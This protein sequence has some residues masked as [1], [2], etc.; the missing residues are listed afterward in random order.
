MAADEISEY[1]ENKTELEEIKSFL[2]SKVGAPFCTNVLRIALNMKEESIASIIV[3]YYSINLDEK[4]IIRA[5][6]TNQV[7]FLYFVYAFNKNYERIL[8]L[9]ADN[10]SEATSDFSDDES[11]YEQKVVQ[12]YEGKYRT[13]TFD[14]LF[15]KILQY[16][17]D[18]Y[19]PFMRIVA[20]WGL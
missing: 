4:M 18:N 13:Y 19:I 6:K 12:K 1:I 14:F 17:P 10:L 11:D 16:L 3:S 20:G 5:I 7:N 2:K 15:K 9:T 8:D